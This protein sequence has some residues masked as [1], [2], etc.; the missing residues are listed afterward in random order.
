VVIFRIVDH[1]W[2]DIV[3]SDGRGYYAYLPAIF[4]FHDLDYRFFFSGVLKLQND[5]TN[6]FLFIIDGEY[7]VK[8]PAG[9]AFLLVPFYLLGLILSFLFGMETSGYSFISQV[10]VSVGALFYLIAGLKSLVSL[11]SFYSDDKKKI[12]WV[13]AALLFG[14]NLLNYSVNE[15]SM[16]HVYS[17]SMMALFLYRFKRWIIDRKSADLLWAAFAI[18][19]VVL[20][21]PVNAIAVFSIFLLTDNWKEM[22]DWLKDILLSPRKLLLAILG[23]GSVVSI[24][25]ILWYLQN[26]HW[27]VWTYL[28]ESFVWNAPEIFKVLFSYRK[29][30]FVYTPLMLLVPV[31]L[32]YLLFKGWWSRAFAVLIFWIPSIYMISSWWCWYYGGSFGQRVFIDFYPVAA[33][34]IAWLFF[35]A[36][37]ERLI[38]FYKLFF[39]LA[40]VVNLIQTYQYKY[41]ILHYDS[42]DKVKYWDV[43]LKTGK[44]YEWKTF[45]NRN[46]NFPDHIQ[47]R[48]R[49]KV[50]MDFE[51]AN[52]DP[53]WSAFRSDYS[54]STVSGNHVAAFGDSLPYSPTYNQ[55]INVEQGNLNIYYRCMLELINGDNPGYLIVELKNDQ[56]SL[57][58]Y[59]K[60]PLKLNK[61]VEIPENSSFSLLEETL[62]IHPPS[63]SWK[64]KIYIYSPDS[65]VKMD[66]LLIGILD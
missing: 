10:M 27:Y 39:V 12:Y 5:Y 28:D 23:A 40:I 66:D 8:Y 14:T 26:G 44:S 64:A 33:L 59:H 45:I 15:P 4:S 7:V 48:V 29:G 11:L 31:S 58:F 32:I 35:G 9:V 22:G 49:Q 55:T 3:Q 54:S 63:G 53:S 20:I 52:S 46:S 37:S 42:M 61:E 51:D 24:Q 17:F 62:K 60:E 47:S 56:D 50:F 38:F 13:L 43:F 65:Q 19:V 34:S 57:I 36:R 6:G 18:G 2:K 16:S 1:G 30:W 21:R 25:P 41:H